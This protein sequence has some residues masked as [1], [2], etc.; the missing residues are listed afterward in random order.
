MAIVKEYVEKIHLQRC[1][2]LLQQITQRQAT[3]DIEDTNTC[4]NLIYA[5]LLH[6]FNTVQQ[7][8]SIF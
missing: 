1:L 4:I 3:D 7:I 5:G 6:V 2:I 8:T